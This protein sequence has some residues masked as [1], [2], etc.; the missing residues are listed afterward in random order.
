MMNRWL[1]IC[2]ILAVLLSVTVLLYW[3]WTWTTAIVIALAMVCPAIMIWGAFQTRKPPS[4]DF[5][6]KAKPHGGK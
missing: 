1:W 3:G 6:P 2:P 5:K 4:D